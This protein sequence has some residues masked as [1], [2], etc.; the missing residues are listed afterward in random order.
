MVTRYQKEHYKDVASILR[1]E[2]EP[3]LKA[4][5]D[6]DGSKAIAC[7]MLAFSRL[8]AADNPDFDR[9]RFLRDCGLEPPTSP[10]LS[11]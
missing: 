7:V 1:D 2:R 6:N 11:L 9:K 3:A 8:F 10:L 5:G 4:L